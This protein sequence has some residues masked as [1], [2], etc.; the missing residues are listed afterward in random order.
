MV[1]KAKVNQKYIE[2]IINKGAD[3][4]QD[5]ISINDEWTMISVRLPKSL[6]KQIDECRET[7]LG[8]TRNAWILQ[9]FQK[10][11]SDEGQ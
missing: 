1:V 4:T 9:Q 10:I 6:L 3:V 8:M 11:L 2:E 5:R 7:S